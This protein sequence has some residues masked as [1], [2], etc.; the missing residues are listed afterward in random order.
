MS[1]KPVTIRNDTDYKSAL[2]LM[3]KHAMHHLP[4]LDSRGT[5]VGVVAERDLL[6][7]AAHY[8]QSAVEVGEVMHRE[9]MTATPEMPI[10]EAAMLMASNRA[11]GLPVVGKA[12]N[13][14]GIITET[15]IFRAFAETLDRGKAAA[16]GNQK[17]Q[18]KQ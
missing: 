7:A 14:V 3:Q 11:G 4:V 16:K 18:E 1:K 2:A 8:L 6:L 10:A 15:D 13:V 17:P 5:L 12:K 9:V